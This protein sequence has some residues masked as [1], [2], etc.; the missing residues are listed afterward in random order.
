[1]PER[2]NQERFIHVIVSVAALGGLLFGY[3]TGVISGAIL[4]IRQS[5]S[6]SPQLQEIVV[7]AVLVGAVIGAAAGGRL[8]D[9]Y[10]RRKL[11]ILSAV[12]FSIGAVGTSLTPL[13]SSWASPSGSLRSSLRCTFRS[14]P[15]LG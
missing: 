9:R 1:M 3:D 2:R 12:I 8:A 15:R 14:L 5:F 7:S 6:L 11:I 13:V 4:F 10:G